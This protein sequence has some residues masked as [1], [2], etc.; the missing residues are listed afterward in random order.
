M[1]SPGARFRDKVTPLFRVTHVREA[2]RHRAARQAVITPLLGPDLLEHDR[3]AEALDKLRERWHARLHALHAAKWTSIPDQISLAYFRNCPPFGVATDTTSHPCNRAVICPFCFAR[4]RVTRPF[5]KL[6]AV[7]Y[8]PSGKG[9]MPLL[10]PD[11]TIV[12]FWCQMLGTRDR[13]KSGDASMV[14]HWSVIRRQIDAYRRDE[15]A[16]FQAKYAS[17]LF[18]PYPMK[19]HLGLVRSGVLLVAGV[20]KADV[21]AQYNAFPGRDL[22]VY[23]TNRKSLM[24]AVT[25][26][27]SYPKR[28]MDATDVA[29]TARFLEV[30]IGTRLSTWY[31]ARVSKDHAFTG[32]LLGGDRSPVLWQYVCPVERIMDDI[33]ASVAI[34]LYASSTSKATVKTATAALKKSY[35]TQT[36]ILLSRPAGSGTRPLWLVPPEKVESRLSESKFSDLSGA[37][38][39]LNEVGSEYV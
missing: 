4:E 27:F 19:E 36:P 34:H 35:E 10:R 13:F 12:S 37:D 15:V 1:L 39:L 38:V 22:R 26:A 6:E 25:H 30:T 2:Y 8:G 31:G 29:R 14:D 28:L 17:V 24:E 7:L 33:S 11:L 20:P 9:T 23:E 32:S 16:M 3:T 5:C 21:I 18:K